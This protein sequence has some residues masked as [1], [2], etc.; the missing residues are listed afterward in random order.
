MQKR[1]Y[2]KNEF[3]IRHDAVAAILR[4]YIIN[5]KHCVVHS[6][7][8]VRGRDGARLEGDNTNLKPDLWWWKDD[9]LFIIEITI[10]YGM[11]TDV[12][13]IHTSTLSLRRQQKLNKY[14]SL[15]NDCKHQFNC[16]ADFSVIILSSLGA[17]PKET[18]DELKKLT[19]T[20]A[21]WK[22]LCKRMVMATLRESM[23]IAYNWRPRSRPNAANLDTVN[24]TNSFGPTTHSD[25]SD[26][27]NISENTSEDIVQS[28]ETSMSECSDEVWNDLI[29]NEA[30]PSNQN[31]IP[32]NDSFVNYSDSDDVDVLTNPGTSPYWLHNVSEGN[33]SEVSIDGQNE[34]V[35]SSDCE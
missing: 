4:E 17:I 25:H 27:D 6:N 11:Y 31:P 12:D 32:V 29:G 10:P 15:V 34:S 21:D 28:V 35:D 8:V 2:R 16:D 9:K 5:N 19:N 1:Q 7:Q 33:S 18:I 22:K 3:T 13:G 26:V 30:A 24:D 23:C 14:D 20:E